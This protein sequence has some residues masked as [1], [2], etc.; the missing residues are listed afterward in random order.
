LYYYVFQLFP[1][2]IFQQPPRFN[3]RSLLYPN[4]RHTLTVCMN[5]GHV[6]NVIH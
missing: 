3:T 1:I 6:T 5:T 2:H 4:Y